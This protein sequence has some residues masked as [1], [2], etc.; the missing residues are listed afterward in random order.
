MSV[1]DVATGERVLCDGSFCPTT[2]HP[3]AVRFLTLTPGGGLR[4][5]RLAGT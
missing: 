2:Y 3:G 5:S 1:W 4:S